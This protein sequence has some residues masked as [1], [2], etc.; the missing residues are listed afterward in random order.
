M[1]KRM[2][3]RETLKLEEVERGNFIVTVITV[4]GDIRFDLS[5]Y[6]GPHYVILLLTVSL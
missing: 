1:F 4:Y 6:V 5:N 2:V 3:N